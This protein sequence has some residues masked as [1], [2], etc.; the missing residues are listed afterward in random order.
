MI[1]SNAFHFDGL[2]RF[3]GWESIMGLQ[4]ENLVLNNA[5]SRCM[6]TPTSAGVA[7]SRGLLYN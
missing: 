6:G 2:D 1:D 4:F 7:V 5:V 3:A